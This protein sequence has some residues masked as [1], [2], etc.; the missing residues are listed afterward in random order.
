ML[1]FHRGGRYLTAAA[2]RIATGAA[3]RPVAAAVVLS[4][5]RRLALL[6]AL[7]AVVAGCGDYG[8]GDDAEDDRAPATTQDAGSGGGYQYP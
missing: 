7:T 5:R 3:N 1:R 2:T 6:A 4:M 8:T